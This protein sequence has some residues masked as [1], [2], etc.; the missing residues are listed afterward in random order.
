MASS[1]VCP[2]RVGLYATNRDVTS[3]FAICN[4]PWL[5][6]QCGNLFNVMGS[7]GKHQCRQHP[8]HVRD[9]GTWSCCG[10]QIFKMRWERHYDIQ[11]MLASTIGKTPYKM[12]PRVLGCQPCDH[13]ASDKPYTEKDDV[14]LDEIAGILT[15][16]QQEGDISERAGFKNSTLR[17][18]KY[19]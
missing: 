3:A 18:C 8:G 15:F 19:D 10:Q 7:I 13:N 5:C 16:I 14:K 11:R 17:R 1:G 12:P 6:A 9:D 2:P 4:K